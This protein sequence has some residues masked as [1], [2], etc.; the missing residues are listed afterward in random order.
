MQ[1]PAPVVLPHAPAAGLARLVDVMDRVEKQVDDINQSELPELEDRQDDIEGKIYSQVCDSVETCV[2]ITNF[3]PLELQA[4]I[5]RLDSTWRQHRRQ[6]PRTL[7][8]L[9][10]HTVLYLSWLKSG[11][12]IENLC[13]LLKIKAATGQHAIARFRQVLK[14]RLEKDW[15]WSQHR[16]EALPNTEFPF[17]GLLVDSTTFHI[18]RPSGTFSEAKV[19]WDGKNHI[20]GMKKEV[21]VLA[22]SP[23]YA[24]FVNKAVPGSKHDYDVLKRGYKRYL[25]FLLKKPNEKLAS[26]QHNSWAALFDNGYQGPASDTGDLRRIFVP[27]KSHVPSS[28][29]TR[30]HLAHLRAPVEQFFGRVA[31]LW[32]VARNRYKWSLEHFDLD[33]DNCCYLTNEHIRHN[34]LTMLDY[35]FKAKHARSQAVLEEARQEKRR[36]QQKE[37]KARRKARLEQGASP[38]ASEAQNGSDRDSDY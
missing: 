38:V 21:G 19:Y 28:E 2:K 8:T 15:H 34:Q 22:A 10:D 31:Q 14:E 27:R 9:A 32:G 17:I 33:I 3:T 5:A 29:I 7:L 6:G 30:E 1:S 25:E 11:L 12:E 18:N 35:N 26:D 23:H 4:L 16:P 36:R 13:A 24:L 37:H 20:Y